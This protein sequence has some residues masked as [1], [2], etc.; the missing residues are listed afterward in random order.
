MH[1]YRRVFDVINIHTYIA[2]L[3]LCRLCLHATFNAFQV[4]KLGSLTQAYIGGIRRADHQVEGR[5]G[6]FIATSFE[7]V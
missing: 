7:N 3:L 4:D 6:S 2:W 1:T 5:G